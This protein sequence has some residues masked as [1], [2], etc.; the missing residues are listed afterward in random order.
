MGFSQK[1][2]VSSVILVVL[3]L[4][5]FSFA[6]AAEEEKE[7]RDTRPERGI[8]VFTEYAG[9]TVPRGETVRMDLILDDKGR[10]DETIDVRLASVP[11][12]W[13]ANVKGG[14]YGV[15]G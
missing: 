6:R 2:V 7:R 11:K 15:S 13:K 9:V 3:V 1:R 5:L 12:G 10:T 8:G 4:F 14:N